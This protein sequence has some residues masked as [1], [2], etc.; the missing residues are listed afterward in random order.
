MAG[1]LPRS[2][3]AALVAA[4]ALLIAHWFDAGVLHDAQIRAGFTYDTAPLVDLTVVAHI[5]TAAG[6]LIVV[7]CAWWT[8]SR[9]VGIGFTIV[10]GLL[11]TLPAITWAYALSINGASPTLPEPIASTLTNWFF[12]LEV[13]VTGAVYTIAGAM[14]LAGLAVLASTFRTPLVSPEPEPPAVAPV[15]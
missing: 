3:I 5:L 11:A 14:F 2:L 15:A 7:S 13:G 9:A 4:V 8:R 12:S 1:K 10:G 6:A